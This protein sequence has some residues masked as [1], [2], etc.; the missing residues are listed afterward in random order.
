LEWL[1]PNWQAPNNIRA[2]TT[3]KR[4]GY[5]RGSYQGLNL[6]THVGDEPEAV[7]INR[8]L[9]VSCLNLPA[10]PK[11]LNQVHGTLVASG[12]ALS[13]LPEAD[14]SISRNVDEVCAVLTADCLPI[15]LCDLKGTCVG[16]VHAGWKGLAA[17]VIESTVKQLS[18]SVETLMA[19]LGPAI[20]PD[21]FEVGKDVVDIF[22]KS[23]VDSKKAFTK[24][25]AQTWKANIYTLAKM[26]L[27][28]L[29]ITQIYGGEYCTYTENDRFYSAR[30]TIHTRKAPTGRMATIIWRTS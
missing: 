29:G 10:E 2:L 30:Q 4:G 24:I 5:S 28:A 7:S 12:N 3:L 9:L 20:G 16:A 15:L 17:G 23:P 1:T 6:A 13:C 27:E 25:N 22:K 26:R 8:R 19:W 14:A 18:V 11:W 21:A